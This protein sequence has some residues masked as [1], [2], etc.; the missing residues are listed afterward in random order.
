[1]SNQAQ[2]KRIAHLVIALDNGGLENLVCRWTVHRNK[3][4]PNSTCIICLDH[5]GEL[6]SDLNNTQV[7][8]VDAQRSRFPYD[9]EAVRRI[10]DICSKEK[11][12]LIHS[13]NLVAHQYG[14]LAA[15]S[16]GIAHIQT[17]HGFNMHCR[18]IKERI[19]A[20][21]M[22][23]LTPMHTAVSEKVGDFMQNF[24]SIPRS[25]IQVIANGVDPHHASEPE[26]INKIRSELSI[27]NDAVVLGSVGRLAHVKGWD[28]FLP[29][30]AKLIQQ[31]EL[32]K[33]QPLHL[34]LV[35][36]GPDRESIESQADELN[37]SKHLH[38]AGFKNECGPYYD[39]FD[40]F[41]MP[42]RSEGLSVALLEAMAAGCPSIATAVGEHTKL[43]KESQSGTLLDASD[44]SDWLEIISETINNQIALSEMGE[45]AKRYV[46]AHYT[47]EK[48]MSAFESLYNNLTN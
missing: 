10:A 36:D 2:R 41:L 7:I 40:I 5:T 18:N 30:F 12:Q 38:F 31:H 4:T 19:R 22:G 28:I 23:R 21:I 15:R 3:R 16:K 25:R 33:A 27:P 1:M 45:K 32:G 43:L 8:C 35:G 39:L 26:V 20:R 6:A 11:I 47:Q 13:H 17:L 29:V 42:S 37:I 34:V 46:E 9:R 24:Y 44:A 48:T 14:A